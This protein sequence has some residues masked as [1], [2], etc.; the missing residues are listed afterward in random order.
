MNAEGDKM[1][2]LDNKLHDY[3]EVNGLYVCQRPGCGYVS[4]HKPYPSYDQLLKI[5]LELEARIDE[6]T[7]LLDDRAA[8]YQFGD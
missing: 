1:P 6:L 2:C 8:E 7:K 4:Q 3:K 5:N